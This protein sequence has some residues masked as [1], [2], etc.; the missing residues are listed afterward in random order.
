LVA[1]GAFY[2]FADYCSGV[3]RT[4]VLFRGHWTMATLMDTAFLVSSFGED[5][6]GELYLVNLGG[7]VYR[8]DPA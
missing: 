8:F 4:L 5:E 7:A 2:V 6:S 3:L 1:S